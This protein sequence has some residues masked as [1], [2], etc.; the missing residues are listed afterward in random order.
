M[1]RLRCLILPVDNLISE[2]YLK[3]RKFSFH[4]RLWLYYPE[5][6]KAQNGMFF[7]LLDSKHPTSHNAWWECHKW[8]RM[9]KRKKEG[10]RKKRIKGQKN[11]FWQ[12]SQLT[13]LKRRKRCYRDVT[14][15]ITDVLSRKNNNW[16]AQSSS[17]GCIIKFEH[18]FLSWLEMPKI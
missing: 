5:S 6:P 13:E 3:E 10:E 17:Y 9:R 7:I 8:F 2:L 11:M 12:L 1:W 18:D 4:S 16:L 15:E 14:W